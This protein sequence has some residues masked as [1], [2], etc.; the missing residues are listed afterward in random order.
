MNFSPWLI[1]GLGAAF[2]FAEYVARVAPSVMVPELMRS[3]NVDALTIGSLSA[4]FSYAYVSMQMPVGVLVDRYGPHRLL[5]VMCIVCGLGCLLFANAGNVVSANFGRFLMGFGA[6]FA[7]VGSLKLAVLWFPANR[8]GLLAG[9]TQAVGMLGAAVGQ[10]PTSIAVSCLG[11]QTTLFAIAIVFLIL[12]ILIGLIVRDRPIH[13]LLIQ[14]PLASDKNVL[15]GSKNVLKNRQSWWN[16]AYAGVIYAPTAAFAEL[17]G[18]TFLAQ[19]YH[20]S[21]RVAATIVSLIFIGIGVGGPLIGWF[22]DRIQLRRPLMLLSAVSCFVLLIF[23]LYLPP[24]TPASVLLIVAFLYGVS[25]TGFTIAY[26]VA[27]EINP[28]GIAGTSVALANMASVIIGALFQPLI[29]WV[30]DLHWDGHMQNGAPLYSAHAFHLAF[31]LL[32]ICLALG[33]L[34]A[35]LVKE[36]YCQSLEIREKQH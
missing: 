4:F 11:W 22:S 6:S 14:E 29:G 12:A 20:L 30:L 8:F 21:L 15:A 7:F 36:T 33:F 19:N 25:N 9:L 3:F 2:F 24:T 26:A 35:F 16:A 1:W 31:I 13:S 32:P 23:M 28:R 18:V 27:S 17:W 34:L 10:A 5:T